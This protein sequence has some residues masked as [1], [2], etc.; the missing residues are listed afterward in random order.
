MRKSLPYLLRTP[1]NLGTQRAISEAK[2]AWV[3][4]PF[5]TWLVYPVT[6][7]RIDFPQARCHY[8]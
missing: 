1:R 2:R 7:D 6:V 5:D 4:A 8:K 3:S